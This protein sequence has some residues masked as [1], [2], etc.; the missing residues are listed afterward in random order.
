MYST[1]NFYKKLSEKETHNEY[2][3]ETVNSTIAG[4]FETGL[5]RLL[6]GADRSVVYSS[7]ADS[8]PFLPYPDPWIRS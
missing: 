3:I 8:V 7:V 1:L 6:T 4:H 2:S 5:E